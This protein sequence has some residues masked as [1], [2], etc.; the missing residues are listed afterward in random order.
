VIAVSRTVTI[1]SAIDRVAPY[2]S[3]FTT[4]AQWDPHTA[5][6]ARLQDGP[7]RGRGPRCPQGRN[8]Y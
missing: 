1:V 8:G 5:E 7:V 3:D 6:C 4:T 2:L